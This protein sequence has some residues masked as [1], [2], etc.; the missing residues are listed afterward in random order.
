MF[1][2]LKLIQSYGSGIR[3][4]KNA[5]KQIGSPELIFEPENDTDDYTL[6]TAYINAEFA[7]IQKEEAELQYAPAQE[8]AQETAQEKNDKLTDEERIIILLSKNPKM[9]RN[10]LAEILNISADAVKRRLE[11]LKKAGKIE[12]RGSTK[13][14]KW[15]VL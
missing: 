2:C 15:I 7:G 1:F 8:T 10:E 14:G 6:V 12:H 4:A 11:K 3:R 9:T 5:L 13:A